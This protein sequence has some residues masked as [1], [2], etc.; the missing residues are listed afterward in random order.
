MNDHNF[1]L[2][3]DDGRFQRMQ[4]LPASTRLQITVMSFGRQRCIMAKIV[5][6]IYSLSRVSIFNYTIP[7]HNLRPEYGSCAS[8]KGG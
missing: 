6:R 1:V 7:S 2:I 3:S 8:S 4:S 5:Q